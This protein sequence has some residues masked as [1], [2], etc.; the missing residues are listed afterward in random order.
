MVLV[1]DMIGTIPCTLTSYDVFKCGLLA[2]NILAGKRARG[3]PYGQYDKRC[4]P[5]ETEYYGVEGELV[6]SRHLGVTMN[7]DIL[8]RGDGGIDMEYHEL[9]VQVKAN[10]WNGKGLVF[11]F[12]SLEKFV[13]DIM[14]GVHIESFVRCEIMGWIT[15]EE[16]K[17]CWHPDDFGYGERVCCWPSQMK[18]IKTLTA[19]YTE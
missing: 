1:S 3:R 19:E 5:F 13:A 16:F 10:H 11:Y 12:D 9:K 15:R 17:G 7:Y 8:P 6:V 14:I 4:T 2:S 18:S